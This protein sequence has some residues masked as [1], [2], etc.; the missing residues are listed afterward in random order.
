MY[1]E[2]EEGLG[3]GF[4]PA[5]PPYPSADWIS[6]CAEIAASWVYTRNVDPEIGWVLLM[7]RIRTE[8]P[9]KAETLNA[10]IDE[11]RIG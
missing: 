6:F 7:E 11:R 2:Q 4:L 9:V 10:A 8:P 5:D 1:I 3:G